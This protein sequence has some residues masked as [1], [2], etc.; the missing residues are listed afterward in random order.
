MAVSKL[1]DDDAGFLAA[2]PETGMGFQLIR[3]T[4]GGH[5][6][7]FLVLNSQYLVPASDRKEMMSHLHEIASQEDV[8]TLDQLKD[9]EEVPLSDR[10][11]VKVKVI[12]SRLDD[13]IPTLERVQ[14]L[15]NEQAL[16]SIQHS[17]EPAAYFR[18]SAD[19][20]DRRVDPK[21]GD[22]AAGTYATTYNDL[23]MVPSGFS[24]VGRYA[25]P[26]PLS[27]KYVYPIVTSAT[28]KKPIHIGTVVPNFGQA[29]GGVEVCFPKGAKMITGIPHPIPRG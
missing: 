6:G 12:A 25:L 16:L 1:N 28:N 14:D 22:F 18:F 4:I 7:R 24:A 3:A 13:T 29:G 21:T 2:K 11:R 15:L 26:N 17:A 23:R 5:T 9:V 27:A 10:E 19:R 20:S 8:K